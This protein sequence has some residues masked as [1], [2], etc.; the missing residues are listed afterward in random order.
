MVSKAVKEGW[1]K[2]DEARA[3]FK[4]S[5]PKA[6]VPTQKPTLYSEEF[7]RFINFK[8]NDQQKEHFNEW[9]QAADVWGLLNVLGEDG[10]KLTVKY[11]ETSKAFN[12]LLMD[13]KKTSPVCGCILSVRA[14]EMAVAIARL[15]FVHVCL[16]GENWERLSLPVEHDW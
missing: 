13:R 5:P 1:E 2:R 4:P 16:A 9:V 6:S 8:P 15:V 11:D 10:Y 12:A 14:S 7:V 3:N